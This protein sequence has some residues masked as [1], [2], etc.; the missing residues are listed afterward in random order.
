MTTVSG[1]YWESPYQLGG[2]FVVNWG[3][4]LLYIIYTYIQ[5][6][7]RHNPQQYFRL[8]IQFPQCHW[9]NF[10]QYGLMFETNYED[11][12]SNHMHTEK[13]TVCWYH[14]NYIIETTL[15]YT[16]RWLWEGPKLS[17][18]DPRCCLSQSNWHRNKPTELRLQPVLRSIQ[19]SHLLLYI[20]RDM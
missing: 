3:L 6:N 18:S 9:S 17:V 7:S 15:L 13:S 20:K 1:L 4:V 19:L 10:E 5:V 16:T 2:V 8:F 14:D 11:D 12:I